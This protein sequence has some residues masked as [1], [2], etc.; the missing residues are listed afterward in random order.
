MGASEASFYLWKKKYGKLGLTE[1]RELLQSRDENARAKIEAWR[2]DYNAHRPHSSLGYQS[3]NEFEAQLARQAASIRQA[4]WSS[5][6]G[7][8]HGERTLE[9]MILA[10]GANYSR[11]TGCNA[12]CD[13]ASQRRSVSFGELKLRAE[14]RNVNA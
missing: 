13:A 9:R 14:W 3:P 10:P 12:E 5:L 8:L 7:S 6:R 11:R 4:S 2:I 1:L